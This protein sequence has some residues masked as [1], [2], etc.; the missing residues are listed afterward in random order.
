MNTLRLGIKKRLLSLQISE[1][2]QGL[3]TSVLGEAT[4]ILLHN[5]EGNITQE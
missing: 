4:P 1:I 3:P 5:Y 2:R